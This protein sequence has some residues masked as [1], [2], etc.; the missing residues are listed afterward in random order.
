[1]CTLPC[2]NGFAHSTLYNTLGSSTKRAWMVRQC[3]DKQSHASRAASQFPVNHCASKCLSPVFS[4]GLTES[5]LLCLDWL[6]HLHWMSFLGSSTIAM[7]LVHQGWCEPQVYSRSASTSDGCDYGFENRTIH[8]GEVVGTN[9]RPHV[10]FPG[11]FIWRQKFVWR[12]ADA[13]TSKLF[14]FVR[15]ID[16]FYALDPEKI[17]MSSRAEHW[18]WVW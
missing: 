12:F 3:P 16:Y 17:Q 9:G 7:G 15:V 10:L 5:V 4:H 11:P 1:M 6:P 14:K 13:V 18:V 2:G 8:S